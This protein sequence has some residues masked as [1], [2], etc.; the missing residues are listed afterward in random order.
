MADINGQ[1]LGLLDA[2]R[3]AGGLRDGIDPDVP[4]LVL[5][6]HAGR[7]AR[8]RALERGADD[9]LGKPF[10]YPE[11]H[12]RV[13]AVLRRCHERPRRV[14]HAGGLVVDRTARRAWVGE[15]EVEL[16][17]KEFEL[18]AALAADPERVHTKAE[19]LKAIWGLGSWA[20]TRTL[21]SHA[22]RLR[23]KLRNAGAGE[24]LVNVW[25]VGYRLSPT[26]LDACA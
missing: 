19:L 1:T 15:T 2:I 21:D 13:R 3:G 20:R 14:I 26:P 16:A 9:V 17:P 24:V 12:A 23:Q 5:S 6:A 7:L 18:L 25:G 8:V 11:L 10:A 4:L 22:F